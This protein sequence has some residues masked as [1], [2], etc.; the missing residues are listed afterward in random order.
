MDEVNADQFQSPLLEDF[1]SQFALEVANSEVDKRRAYA[2]RHEVF[3]E[4]LNYEL[5]EDLDSPLERDKYDR[6]AILCLLRH[7]PSGED[8]GCLRVA[9]A[10]P[11]S[12]NRFVFPFEENCGERL[13]HDLY[14][15]RRFP[16]PLQP[17]RGRRCPRPLR[18]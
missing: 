17:R 12:A 16:R 7:R 13:N 11:E 18:R 4:E 2:V 15:P 14:H 9:V 6:N 8:A 1:K 3:R 10:P 5:G